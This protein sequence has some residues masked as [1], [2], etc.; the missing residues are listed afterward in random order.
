MWFSSQG[1]SENGYIGRPRAI[2]T[3]TNIANDYAAYFA[4]LDWFAPPERPERQRNAQGEQSQRV[5][6]AKNAAARSFEGGSL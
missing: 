4:P 2:P 3:K 6:N 5:K 1:E